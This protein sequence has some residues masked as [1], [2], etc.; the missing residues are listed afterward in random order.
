LPSQQIGTPTAPP[1]PADAATPDG[2]QGTAEGGEQ[3]AS[4][5][6]A[7]SAAATPPQQQTAA[8][9]PLPPTIP[10]VEPGAGSLA[11]VPVAELVEESQYGPLPK[12]TSDGRRPIDVY[13]RPS[14]YA[15]KGTAG[16]PARIAIL[17][18]GLG[19][20]DSPPAMSEAAS[21]ISIA[22]APMPLVGL[23]HKGA[24]TD[25]VLCRSLEPPT[26]PRGPGPHRAVD[27]AACRGEHEA[28]AMAY[29]LYRLCGHYP[30]LGASS[31]DPG[32]APP[33]L[34]EVKARSLLYVDDG[35]VQGSTVQ[36]AGAIRPRL[37]G[38]HVQIGG[39][40]SPGRYRQAA[41]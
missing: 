24:P 23:G 36:I 22:M 9:A 21:A 15:V 27:V 14:R 33:V 29:A 41:G 28:A 35:S 34:E 8:V 39:N 17:V 7:P 20:P 5:A 13:A 2:R 18:S 3:S 32:C 25:G 10:D 30:T 12:V 37:F 38:R 11:P 31:G 40:A 4:T 6:P 1:S 19:L 26:I 16:E